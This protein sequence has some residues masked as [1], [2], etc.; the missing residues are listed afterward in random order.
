MTR[1]RPGGDPLRSFERDSAVACLA[2]AGAGWALSGWR[3]DVAG[4]VLAG[5]G[6]MAVS[7]AFIKGGVEGAARALAEAAG[8]SRRRVRLALAVVKFLTRYALLAVAA[9]GILTCFH[10]HPAGVLAG[11]LSPFLGA[12]GQ[13]VRMSRARTRAGRPL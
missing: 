10:L 7:Y 9:Y 6:L 2:M 12:L 4:G 3:L 5:G 8:T 1:V 13:L 11:A